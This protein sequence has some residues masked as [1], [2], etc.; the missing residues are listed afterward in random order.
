MSSVENE[1]SGEKGG[2]SPSDAIDGEGGELHEGEIYEGM[3]GLNEILLKRAQATRKDFYKRAFDLIKN[4]DNPPE[5]VPRITVE[6]MRE[7]AR[8]RGYTP[9]F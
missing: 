3:P 9:G 5:G 7:S 4:L 2:Q 8:K 6:D 1:E